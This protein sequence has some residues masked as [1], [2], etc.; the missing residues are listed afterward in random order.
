MDSTQGHTVI[1]K[2]WKMKKKEKLIKSKER[3]S[4]FAEVYTPEWLVK[5]MCN[6]IPKE[7]WESIDKT[8]LEPAC[9]NGNF[10]VEI[11]LRKLCLCKNEDDC[12]RALDSIYG[13]DIQADNVEESKERMLYIVQSIYGLFIREEAKEILDKRIICGDSLKIMWELEGKDWEEIL[14]EI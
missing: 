5:D 10:L 1:T 6:M 3:V 2:K 14:D 13:I 9:G 12:L 4:K 7:M 11:L 8:V